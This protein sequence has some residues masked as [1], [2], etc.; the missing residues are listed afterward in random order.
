MTLCFYHLKLLF[1]KEFGCICWSNLEITS[2]IQANNLIL[3]LGLNYLI[4][5][6]D[7]FARFLLF[8]V[9][10]CNSCLCNQD[11]LLCNDIQAIFDNLLNNHHHQDCYHHHIIAR[12][13]F[14]PHNTI[15]TFRL[16]DR[17]QIKAY[18]SYIYSNWN[19]LCSHLDMLSKLYD[20]Y[21]NM[22]QCC[23]WKDLHLVFVH[24]F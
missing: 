19:S 13:S 17:I 16:V 15:Y 3:S 10:T 1:L 11:Y 24:L 12:T 9:C 23:I 6:F 18:I 5:L 22:F 20:D 7:Q 8:L 4:F 2:M 21:Q 14:R